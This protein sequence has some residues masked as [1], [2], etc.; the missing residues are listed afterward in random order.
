MLQARQSGNA[1]GNANGGAPDL[2]EL[3]QDAER[4]GQGTAPAEI[5]DM[6]DDDFATLMPVRCFEFAFDASHTPLH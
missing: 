1:N 3:I 6:D 4:I 5:I 2:D